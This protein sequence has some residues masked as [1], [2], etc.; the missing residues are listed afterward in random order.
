M[1]DTANSSLTDYIIA[2]EVIGLDGLAWFT[3]LWTCSTRVYG[4]VDICTDRKNLNI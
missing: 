4:I 2:V 3:E 1:E